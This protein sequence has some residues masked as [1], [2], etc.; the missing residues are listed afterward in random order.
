MLPFYMEAHRLFL[1]YF[2]FT[3]RYS[4]NIQFLVE[5]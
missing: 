2:L 4:N 1:S 5:H 3:I